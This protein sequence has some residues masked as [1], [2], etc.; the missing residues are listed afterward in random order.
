MSITNAQIRAARGIL[1]WSQGDLAEHTGISVTSIGGIENGQTTPRESTQNIIQKTF[2]NHNIEFLPDSGV[3][4]RKSDVRIFEGRQ[5]FVDFFDL[6]YE[7]VKNT[8]GEICASNV[9]ENKFLKWAGESANEHMPRMAQVP[10]LQ[11]KVLLK[12]GDYNFIASD[13]AEY[14]WLPEAYFS[15]VP[16]Y[17]FGDKLGILFLETEPNIIV[18]DYP[19]VTEAFRAQFHAMWHHAIIPDTYN[20]QTR[21]TVNSS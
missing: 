13:Y 4:M 8:G 20:A 5:G 16:F 3:R 7:T 18:L 11:F 1:N 10:N 2:E 9:E 19:A 17:A 21:V 15:S 14:R 12:E 6:V